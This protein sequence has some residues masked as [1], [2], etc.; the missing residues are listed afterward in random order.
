M[1][2][3]PRR[4]ALL[5]LLLS[6]SLAAT[7]AATLAACGQDDGPPPPAVGSV[8]VETLAPQPLTLTRHLPG[9][10]N[11][12]LVAEVRPQVSGIIEQRLFTEGG[13]VKAGQPLYQ[14]DDAVYKAEHM[15]AEAA[16]LRARA[17]LNSTQLA[18]RRAEELIKIDA[19]SQQD[20]E[21]A[22]AALKEAE[23]DVKSAAAAVEQARITLGYAQITAPISGRIGKSS[24]TPGALVTANQPQALSTVQQLDPIY[25]DL[26]QSSSEWLQ[27]RKDLAAGEIEQT[28]VPVTILLEDGSRYQYPGKLTFADVS[29]DPT[30]GSFLLRVLVPNPDSLL[31]PGMYVRAVVSM[32]ERHNAIL[33]PQ[34]GITRD[35]RGNATALVVG[36]DDKVERR[37]VTVSRAIGNR[38][39][40]ENGLA[41]GD[42]IIIAGLQKI[43]PGMTVEYTE[44]GEPQA[45]APA[46]PA[47]P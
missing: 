39:L 2:C 12:F 41:A 16:L 47:Q 35:P 4:R 29:V 36:A 17:T 33:A 30:T 6:L 1:F 23:A 10:T 8:I 20:Y 34:Q 38:W 14:I 37:S 27:L 7:L 24:V 11:A 31:L 44:T 28:D 45:A 42:K 5:P 43:Q 32:G 22:T 9:R 21:E 26:T 25:V 19:I 13:L 46:A 15:G 3:A 18:A 40:V